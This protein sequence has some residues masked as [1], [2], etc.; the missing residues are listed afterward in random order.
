MKSRL[1]YKLLLLVGFAL[2][3]TS[4]EMI[5]DYYSPPEPPEPEKEVHYMNVATYDDK[6]G[7]PI[8]GIRV[9]ALTR[10]TTL[11]YDFDTHTYYRVLVIDTLAVMHTDSTGKNALFTKIYPMTRYDIV[12]EDVDGPENGEYNSKQ[13][14]LNLD[15]EYHKVGYSEW[16]RI[17][18]DEIVPL[19]LRKK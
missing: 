10:H 7:S 17:T 4:C 16:D 2:I 13:T 19:K 6:T 8:V 9:S 1:T 11:E 5:A 14:T 18:E 3:A 15:E 12:A